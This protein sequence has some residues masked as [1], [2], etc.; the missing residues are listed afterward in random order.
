LKATSARG[1]G[2]A[3]DQNRRLRPRAAEYNTSIV[4]GG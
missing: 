1:S 3:I 2:S 4:T